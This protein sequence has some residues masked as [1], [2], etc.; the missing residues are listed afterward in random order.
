MYKNVD[1][2]LVCTVL[3]YYC[4]ISTACVNTDCSVLISCRLT[5]KMALRLFC[6]VLSIVVFHCIG[7]GETYKTLDAKRSRME[8]LIKE[9]ADI[10][11]TCHKGFYH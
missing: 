4:T 11:K 5:V 2:L 8:L 6:V 7:K 10:E 3:V 9:V 1:L